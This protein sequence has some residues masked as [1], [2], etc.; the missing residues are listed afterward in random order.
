MHLN[1]CM[2]ISFHLKWCA[3]LGNC[4]RG[5]TWKTNGRV[6]LTCPDHSRVLTV[7]SVWPSRPLLRPG[8]YSGN[9][10]I[11]GCAVQTI[12]SLQ[13]SWPI[14]AP[15]RLFQ[16]PSQY[17]KVFFY[18]LPWLQKVFFYSKLQTIDFLRKVNRYHCRKGF[19]LHSTGLQDHSIVVV[20]HRFQKRFFFTPIKVF[21]YT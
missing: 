14:H 8:H 4:D 18:T 2:W 20:K 16:T 6:L 7:Q 19:F 10:A 5:Y 9:G 15:G 21:F 17:V 13:A 3:N 11:T 12:P 1:V